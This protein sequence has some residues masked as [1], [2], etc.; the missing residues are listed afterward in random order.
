M[1]YPEPTV[2]NYPA[3]LLIGRSA[4]MSVA[5]NTTA[6]LWRSVSPRL[7]EVAGRTDEQRIS[8]QIYPANYF[9]SFLPTR[10]FVKWAGVAV[11]AGQEPPPGW[12]VLNIPA[13]CYAVFHHQG[14]GN[15]PAIFRYIFSQWLPASPYRLDDR[16]HFEVLEPGYRPNDPAAEE[17]IYIPVIERTQ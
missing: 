9:S 1:N 12:S 7:R 10:R 3:T 6:A 4:E 15:D 14:P 5:E 17:R 16:P 13:G 11:R 2:V 8:L